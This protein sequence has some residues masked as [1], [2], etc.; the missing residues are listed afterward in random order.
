MK[1]IIQYLARRIAGIELETW[2]HQL[3]IEEL[4]KNLQELRNELGIPTRITDRPPSMDGPR[5]IN[6]Q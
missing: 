2:E 4:E 5:T 1:S 6:E 3:R